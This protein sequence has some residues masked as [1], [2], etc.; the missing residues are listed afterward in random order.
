MLFNSIF[1]IVVLAFVRLNPLF[2]TVS[3]ASF[4]GR[5][6]TQA[7]AQ[8]DNLIFWAIYQTVGKRKYASSTSESSK[9]KFVSVYS[10]SMMAVSV[11]SELLS[12]DLVETYNIFLC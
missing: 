5:C 8:N 10:N 9:I 3:Y 11:V 12:P 6:T 2:S 1:D 7:V 4:L